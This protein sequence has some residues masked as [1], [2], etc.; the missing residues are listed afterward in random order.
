MCYVDVC[1]AIRYQPTDETSATSTLTQ[2]FDLIYHNKTIS[3][4]F[5]KTSNFK[6]QIQTYVRD[7][8]SSYYRTISC[9]VISSSKVR[10]GAFT[11]FF[12]SS[13]FVISCDVPSFACYLFHIYI[14]IS[15][16]YS[17]FSSSCHVI[18]FFFY[19]YFL[20]YIYLT[21]NGSYNFLHRK[22]RRIYSPAWL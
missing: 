19:F 12:S 11:I 9:H 6:S 16:F 17:L 13:T 7:A 4:D 10:V 21:G 1:I 5:P 2:Y 3:M 14:R 15:C 8:R 18:V 20:N 22:R